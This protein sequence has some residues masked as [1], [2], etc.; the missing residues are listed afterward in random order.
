MAKKDRE[1]LSEVGTDHERALALVK[2]DNV[3]YQNNFDF[4][5]FLGVIIVTS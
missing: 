3:A 5:Y 4:S 1:A 2:E